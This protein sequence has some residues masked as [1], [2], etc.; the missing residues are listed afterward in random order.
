MLHLS[1]YARVRV[2][3]ILYTYVCTYIYRSTYI[4]IS[5]CFRGPVCSCQEVRRGRHC[6]HTQDAGSAL[7]YSSKSGR[8]SNL[9]TQENIFPFI[10][11][12]TILAY[13]PLFPILFRLS[14]FMPLLLHH[15]PCSFP[16]IHQWTPSV[17]CLF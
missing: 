8:K 7:R 14:D 1:R 17:T 11:I 9:N 4:S 6:V 16:A 3:Q 10:Y 5:F 13:M 15:S 12:P 2:G